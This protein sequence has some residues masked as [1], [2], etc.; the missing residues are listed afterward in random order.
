[1][2]TQLLADDGGVYHFSGMPAVSWAA[3]AERHHDASELTLRK[4]GLCDFRLSNTGAATPEFKL[5]ASILDDFGIEQPVLIAWI[6]LMC[7]TEFI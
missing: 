5:I 3:F 2:A 6:S 1:M 4:L 7:L